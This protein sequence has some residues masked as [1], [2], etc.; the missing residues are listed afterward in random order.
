MKNR[1]IG[2]TNEKRGYIITLEQLF[3][4]LQEDFMER[5]NL[6]EN[7]EMN[8]KRTTFENSETPYYLADLFRVFAD[9]TRIRILYVI[10]EKEVCVGDIAAELNMTVSAISH[11]LRILKTAQLVKYRKEGK[12]SF[13]SLADDHVKT[14]MAQG[15]EHIE[16]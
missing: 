5:E 3:N 16:E 4:R 14:I 6:I 1:L 10:M 8:G 12:I 11:Q 2:L 15:I 7:E 9:S 13:Y